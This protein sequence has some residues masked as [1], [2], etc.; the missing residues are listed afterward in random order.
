MLALIDRGV[1]CQ[2]TSGVTAATAAPLATGLP[3]GRTVTIVAGNADPVYPPTDLSALA[4][5]LG[6]LVVLVGRS[7]QGTIAASLAEAGLDPDTPAAVVHGASRGSRVVHTHLSALGDHRLPP[8]S[9]VVIGPEK[10]ENRCTYLTAG[11]TSRRRP[12]ASPWPG[13]R[14][15][16]PPAGPR[17]R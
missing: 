7:R 3:R 4:D 1:V 9:T 15:P 14:W 8:P 12:P 6:S 11:S 17:R 2:V 13:R 16:W 5:P 10:V